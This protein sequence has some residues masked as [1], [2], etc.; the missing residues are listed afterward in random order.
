MRRFLKFWDVLLAAAIALCFAVWVAP[1]VW[2]EI[3]SEMI[4]FFGIQA[5]AVLPAMIFTAGL[6]R[7][8][9]ITV[10]EVRRYQKALR[11]QMLFW[12]VLLAL[13][14]LTAGSLIFAKAISWK[15]H[16]EF[17]PLMWSYDAS[18][19]VNAVIAFFASLA[20]LRT[21]PFVRGVLSLL[22]LNAELA[23]KAIVKRNAEEVK[24]MDRI[25]SGHPF[26]KPEGFGRVTT[27]H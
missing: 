18:W 4:T 2:K 16:I 24:E 1:T 17:A 5:A 13:D 3:T 14:F 7:P 15:L 22:R 9:G 8:E 25:A 27:R 19:S 12:I 23:E 6:L 20:A 26:N 11:K 10:S 21:I